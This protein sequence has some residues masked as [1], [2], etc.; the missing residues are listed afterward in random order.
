MQNN[1]SIVTLICEHSNKIGVSL[2]TNFLEANVVNI[3]ILLFGL[4]YVLKQFLGSILITR[5]EKVLFAIRECEER[6]QQANDRLNESEKQLNQTQNIIDQIL[7]EAEATS[8][9]VSQSILD[10]GKNEVDKLINAS[11][12]SLILA[13]NQI[14]Q[15]IKQ[16]ITTLAIQKVSLQL[17]STIDASMQSELIDNN[18]KKLKGEI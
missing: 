2:N 4:I 8:K 10:Q 11:K 7:N 16:Q 6:L 1:Y 9:K 13:E 17:Q 3:L 5:Q 18:I 15:E 14:K 12:A